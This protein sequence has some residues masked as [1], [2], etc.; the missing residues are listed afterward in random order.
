MDRGAE[1]MWIFKLKETLLE[2][3]RKSDLNFSICRVS[4][5]L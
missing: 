2:G 4:D 1:K 5:E 3:F